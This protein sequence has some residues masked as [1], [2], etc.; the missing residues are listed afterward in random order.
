MESFLQDIRYS[1]RSLLETP[2]FTAV[3]IIVLALGIGANTAIFTVVNAVLLRPLPYPG[4]EQ[5]AML[6]ETNPRFQIGLDTLPVTPGNFMDWR[7][8]NSVFEYVSAL[9]VGRW[10]LTVFRLMGIGLKLG[11]AFRDDE[12]KPGTEK[13]V[14]I[15]H[16]L[17]QR[18]FAG[19]PD[20]LGK[21]M[22]LD[23]E[24]YTVIG[25]GP[26]GFQFPRARELP[27][28]VGV[29]TQTDLWR[30]MILG[31]DFVNKKRANHQLC[32]MAKLK[33]GVTSERAQIEMAAIAERLE[34][35]YPDSNQGIG[36][37]V[38][39]LNEQVVGN[40]R[41]ALLVLMGTVGLVLL[42]ACANVANLLLARSSA[43]QKEIAIRTALGASRGRI[44]RQLL[45]EALL[46]SM[47]AAV[48]GTL[49][50]LWAIKAMLSLSHE[51][52]PRAYEISADVR[53]LGFTVA[54]ALLTSV[55]FGLTPALQASKINL[56]ESLKEGSRGLSGAQR[57]NHVRS[58]LVIS[59]VALS[60]VLLIGAGLLIKSLAT[61]LKVDP[62]FKPDNTLTM[63]IAL[64]GSKYPS[65]KQQIAF[66][67][68]VTHRVE[69]L[70][71]V[72]SVG[73]ISSAP[74]SGGVYAGGFS[75]E[76]RVRAS[77]TD[78]LVADRRMISPE[79]FNALGIPLLKG[80][81]FTDRD[82]QAATGVVVVSE[83]WARRFLPNEDPIDK[84]IKLGGRDSTRPWLSIVGIAGDVRDTAL[85]SDARPCL[86]IPYP[87]FPSSGMTLVVRAAFDPARLISGI[88]DEVW[89]VDKEQPVTDLKTMDQYIADSVS[90]R[91]FN[92]LL[93]AIFASL[94][95]VLASVGIYA[96]IAYSVTERTHEIG[97]RVA[98]GA[99]SSHVIK[100]VVGRGIAL[101]VVGVM[102]GLAGALALTRVM[103]S[104][105]YGVSATDPMT[106]LIVSML[107]FS[108]ALLA[109]Y[110][111]ARR[112]SKV[113]PMV[114]LRRE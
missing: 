42:I 96:V 10:D 28:F 24:S 79:Y 14:V 76:G 21:T 5:L 80:R 57:S 90:P 54:I 7:E 110:V 104:L 102:I 38:V 105:L 64:P 55:I 6:W 78:D 46:I 17:W 75:I 65:A 107:L 77:E 93:L 71:G 87:Q 13:V 35:S 23:R 67:Q 45:T 111:P 99:Q 2:G 43:R 53:V 51:N 32:V 49:L 81:G 101:V 85:E 26:E 9:G 109:S 52:I 70:P 108:V 112:A 33:P 59:E 11:R 8:Q 25:V 103:T 40:V 69:A 48:A 74:L 84:R 72:Q 1:V 82:D 36:V 27:Y 12:E 92:A 83:S 98:L 62:G 31:D 68:E 3:A 16:S 61:L 63:H 58:L 37:K 34:Q 18:R 44:V 91:R 19:E 30:P 56:S 4:S 41:A 29:A 60:L 89:A 95:L 86:Y 100:L 106:F 39:P 15:S 97:I 50:S 113:D 47:T 73:L 66:F 20:V 94:A 88:R 22:T 114:S